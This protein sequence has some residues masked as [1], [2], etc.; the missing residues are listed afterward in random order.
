MKHQRIQNH[1]SRTAHLQM[2]QIE[3]IFTNFSYNQN[4]PQKYKIFTDVQKFFGQ[5]QNEKNILS[6]DCYR[7]QIVQFVF[8]YRLWGAIYCEL[9]EHLTLHKIS[10]LKLS[11]IACI[12]HSKRKYW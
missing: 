8:L 3:N 6:P 4:I 7:Q 9:E 5:S 1:F 10:E 2:S 11:F 12:V